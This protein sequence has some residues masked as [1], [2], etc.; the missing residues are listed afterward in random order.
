L[1]QNVQDET[2]GWLQIRNKRF[3]VMNAATFN[4]I[5]GLAR[6]AEQLSGAVVL[7]RQA[8]QLV[9][10]TPTDSLAIQHLRDL[11]VHLE[12]VNG[13]PLDVHLQLHFDPDEQ[14]DGTDF[15]DLELDPAKVRRPLTQNRA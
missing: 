15:S 14:A 3:A 12:D 11:T 1:L 9:L 5:W 10:R 7:V 8:V 2:V 6:A 13:K 4:H